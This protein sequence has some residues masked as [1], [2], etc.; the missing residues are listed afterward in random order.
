M[1]CSLDMLQLPQQCLCLFWILY[2]SLQR[3]LREQEVLSIIVSNLFN[4]THKKRQ[5]NALWHKA[6]CTFQV[7]FLSVGHKCESDANIYDYGTWGSRRPHGEDMELFTHFVKRFG[8]QILTQPTNES[9]P[10]HSSSLIWY[11]KWTIN[12]LI[13]LFLNLLFFTHKRSF[14]QG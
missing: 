12:V 11:C 7:H 10:K 1:K 9:I 13:L 3:S 14:H 8:N 2:I 4:W 5:R 6:F